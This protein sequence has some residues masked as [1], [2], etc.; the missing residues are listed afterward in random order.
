MLIVKTFRKN[1][2]KTGTFFFLILPGKRKMEIDEA[3]N[4]ASSLLPNKI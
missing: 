1:I 2:N 3:A 4:I